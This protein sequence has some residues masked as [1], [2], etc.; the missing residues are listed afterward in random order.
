MS[1]QKILG[2]KAGPVMNK[3]LAF[4]IGTEEIPA[5]DLEKATSKFSE[6]IESSLDDAKIP[7][8][9]IKIYSSPRRIACVIDDVA[10]ETEAINEVHKGP[11]TKIA[12]DESGAPTKAAIGFARGKGV[13]VEDLKVRE[14]VGVEYV[15]AETNIPAVNTSDILPEILMSMIEDIHWPKSMKWGSHRE[16]FSRPVRWIVAM[17]DKD[18]IEL[19]YAGVKSS[20][21]TMGHR[22]LAPGK[23][24][25]ASAQDYEDV[26]RDA[27]VVPTQDERKALIEKGASAIEAANPGCNVVLPAKTLTEVINLSEFPTVLCGEFDKEFLAVPEEIIVDAMLMHQRYFPIYKDGVLQNKFVIVSNG[28]PDCSEVIIDGNERVVAARLYDAKFFYEEDLK[29]PLESYVDRLDEVVFQ[30]KLGTMLD[31]TNR[32]EKLAAK[33]C[34]EAA[35]SDYETGLI[36]KAARLAKAD[37]ITNAVVEFTSVQGIMGSY[38]A[39]AQGEEVEVAEA[40]ADHYKP[41]FAGDNPPEG[42]VGKVVAVADKIDTICGLFAVG[43][44]P[45][46]TSDPFA[47]RRSALGVI[48]IMQTGL[49]ISLEK[50]LSESLDIY[51][52]NGLEFNKAEVLEQLI[53]FFITRTRVMLHD[54]G[55]SYDAIDAVLAVGIVEPITLIERTE[56]LTEAIS[57]S[58]ELF[59]D[60]ATAYARANNLR[61]PESGT[62]IDASLFNSEE[63][64]LLKAI[65]E[66]TTKVNVNLGEG[67]YSQALSDL[68]GLR[69]PIDSFFESTM[70]MDEDLELRANR[71]KLLNRF[72]EVFVNIA[73]FSLIQHKKTKK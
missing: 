44:L 64:E 71:M 42:I 13:E 56:A 1:I 67:L 8:G 61:D 36:A 37:L 51:L 60:L 5:F 66:V 39:K 21:F 4:E 27:K 22:A 73:D 26:V 2:V 11:S 55:N 28:N 65:E 9:E 30:E 35:I 45:T 15:F 54:S 46:G 10:S 32:V 29:K 16:L 58:P 18:V 33:I 24:E 34:L 7:Y 14:D 19:E 12:F 23:H 38:Y 43:Q 20:N 17:L 57:K 52:E 40:I 53:D 63:S 59:E 68:A 72:T 50:S 48:A 47:L 3:T 31:K 25:I 70:I 62:A 41:R 6:I 69:A 49:D